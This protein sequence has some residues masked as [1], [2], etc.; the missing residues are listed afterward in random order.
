MNKGD[1]AKYELAGP[2]CV[3]GVTFPDWPASAAGSPRPATGE[4]GGSDRQLQD[5][6][7]CPSTPPVTGC[8]PTFLRPVM[9]VSQGVDSVAPN[10]SAD[11]VV[12]PGR[13]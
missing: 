8:V 13:G 11:G 7:Y 4:A 6:V 3:A 12:S 5:L 1:P 10:H 9:G 2:H